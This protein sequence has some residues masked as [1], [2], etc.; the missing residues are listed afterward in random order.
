LI[1]IGWAQAS[2]IPGVIDVL[3]EIAD[4][5]ASLGQD[6]W[7][8]SSFTYEAVGAWIERRELAVARLDGKVIGTMLVQP[9]DHLFWPDRP[10]GEAFY[11]HKL[12][13]SRK[14][15]VD[16]G[17]AGPFIAFAEAATREA[18]RPLLRL[19]C[20][21]DE[22]LCAVYERLGFQRLD[23]VEPEPGLISWRWER[24]V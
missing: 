14:V 20:A 15:P 11:V 16:G 1:D 6:R 24:G 2:D 22:R 12:T 9:A 21:L 7:R 17:L 19:D 4:F 23:I 18:G 5:R 8:K 10:D 3:C 13:R